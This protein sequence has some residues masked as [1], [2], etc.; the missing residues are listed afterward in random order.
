M[1]EEGMNDSEIIN[2]IEM[3]PFGHLPK[4]RL[5]RISDV[6]GVRVGHSTMS[7]GE[8]QT[9]VT[10]ILPSEGNIYQNK[11]PAASDVING[12]GKSVGLVQIDELGQLE[13]P[14][15]LTNT[16]NV[17]K[18][19]D[20][21]VDY[22]ISL[23]HRD[24]IELKTF[25]PVVG[26]CNDSFLND[27]IKKRVDSKMVFEAIYS[28]TEDFE[29][30][31]IGGGRGMSCHQIKGGIGSASRLMKIGDATYTLG[32]L[33]QANHGKRKDLMIGKY[34]VGDLIT[35]AFA[36]PTEPES[37]KGSIIIVMATDLPLSDRQIKRVIKR[38]SVGISRVGGHIGHGSGEIA[39]GFSTANSIPHDYPGAFID[40]KHLNENLMDLPFRAMIEATEEAIVH[41]LLYAETVR[42]YNGNLRRGLV[43][44][45]QK[46][47]L[48]L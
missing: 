34:P 47:Q 18:V 4:G 15:A 16:L 20:A 32:V 21:L 9:G 8:I 13:S 43:E 10:V 33:V 17:G 45:I 23:C 19:S 29:Q 1:G 30:G 40:Q 42:G 38:A 39:I 5:N 2:K 11:L 22:M 26:E 3:M 35:S 31:A 41:A 25:N 48:K 12:F 6:P 7:N 28:A 14:I 46:Y 24:G 36:D 44:I 37:D 27:I